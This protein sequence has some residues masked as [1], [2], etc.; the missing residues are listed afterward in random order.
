MNA[1]VILAQPKKQ[2]FNSAI[3]AEIV[4]SLGQQG[5]DPVGLIDLYADAFNPVMPQEELPRKFSFDETTL[6]YQERIQAA[7]RVVFVYPDWWGGPPAIMK[8]FLDRVFRPG[9][10]Y[11]FREA[12]FKNADAPGLFSQK[13]FDVFITTD[14]REPESGILND[15]PP[16]MV[17]KENVL[18]FCGVTEADVHVFWNLRHSTYAQRKAWLDSIHSMLAI[19]PR[20]AQD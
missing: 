12:D 4:R 7:D 9:I 3:A 16:V 6:R 10:A 13:R 20:S 18:T 1:L 19:Q 5:Y 15:W 14:A 17:W 11:G 8:G 2:S